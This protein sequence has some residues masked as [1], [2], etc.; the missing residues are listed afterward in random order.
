MN[1]N[2]RPTVG[3]LFD[4]LTEPYINQLICNI[5]NTAKEYDINIIGYCSGSY[6][7]PNYYHIQRTILYDFINVDILDGII[8]L[9]G[10]IGNYVNKS[11]LLNL[12]SRYSKIP[13]V[14]IG[15]YLDGVPSIIIDNKRGMSDLIKHLIEEHNCKKIAYI[16]G[17]ETAHDAIE[18][19]EAYKESLKKHN[20]D[21]DEKLI[22]HGNFERLY[23]YK[24]VQI[25]KERK[26]TFDA[27]IGANDNMAIYAMKELM[28]NGFKIP[29]DIA[30]AGFDNINECMS[31]SPALTSVAQPFYEIAK[32]SIDCILSLINKKQIPEKIVIPATLVVRESCGC[33]TYKKIKN[34]NKSFIKKTIDIKDLNEI[35]YQ[36]NKNFNMMM[37]KISVKEWA[38]K[39][40]EELIKYA[41]N[42][43]NNYLIF[44][45]DIIENLLIN[46]ETINEIYKYIEY[47]F[48]IIQ[49]Y[50]KQNNEIFKIK[51][52]AVA[53]FCFKID[54][55]LTKKR[56][57]IEDDINIVN[58]ITE[59]LINAYE[60]KQ[61][62]KVIINEFSLLHLKSCYLC[63]YK[64]KTY[65]NSIVFAFFDKLN[66]HDKIQE[67]KL[68]PTIN[69][70][71]NKM[72]F[73]YKYQYIVFDLFVK[74]EQIGYVLFEAINY[75]GK[76]YESLA[77]QLSYAIKGSLLTSELKKYTQKLERKVKER[78][79][80]LED[81][82]KKLKELDSLKND[83]I[84]NITHEFRSPL[85]VILGISELNMLKTEE[86]ENYEIIHEASIKL[87]K[88]IDRLLHL[89][90][91]DAGIIKLNIS[92]INPSVFLDKII[93]YYSLALKITN[94][95]IIK[96]L[97]STKIDDFYSDREKLE[98]IINNI[99]S[100]S[101][102]FVD[103]DNGI[104]N[105]ELYDNKDFIL[106]IISDNGIGI[107]KNQ[108]NNIFNRFDQANTK[109]T[110]KY[111]GTGIGLAYAKQLINFMKG[112]IWAESEGEGKGAK[113]L[114][115][116]KKG[117][118]HFNIK[119]I[120]IKKDDFTNTNENIEILKAK[121]NEDYNNDHLQILFN[122]LN[123]ENEYEHHKGKI[124]IIDD[125][126]NIRKIIM[127]YLI[128][129]NFQNFILASNGYT[130]INAIYKYH[131][132][133]II[134]DYNLNDI[135]GDV[136]HNE[137]LTNP[138]YKNIPFVFLSA[139][140]DQNIINER[141]E[142]G[143][144][145]YIKK[146]I[147][148]KEFI[149]TINN[150]LVKYFE[151]KK[152]IKLASIDELTGLHNRR[153]I[154][155]N[156]KHEVSLRYYRNISI[157]FFDIDDFKEINDKFG[158][159]IGDIVIKEV[160]KIIKDTI[161]SYD[162]A[163]RYGGDEFVI[164]LPDTNLENAII[165]AEKL[166]NNIENNR[167]N[168]ENN[169][170]KITSSFGVSS[171]LENEEYICNSLNIK[172]L[173]YIYEI[174]NPKNENWDLIE[175]YKEYIA[176]ILIKMADISLYKAKQNICRK[177]GFI[178]QN[179]KFTDNK[180]PEC[181]S[182]DIIKGKNKVVYFDIT[183]QR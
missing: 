91:I 176:N 175:K 157:I 155:N 46:D 160:G 124:L 18:R 67:N 85:T 106:I 93:N 137:I 3:I 42:Q 84:A 39:I 82:N 16:N 8:A 146:P 144:S 183:I 83:F 37:E 158:H 135:K 12:Y 153:S 94:I 123:N 100:N 154:L 142:R 54:E 63:L 51:N 80:E 52:E 40:I 127:N 149:I 177:C 9:S 103:K 13:I 172:S 122:N 49:Q 19:F 31:N 121:F 90:Q 1:T 25:F 113:F 44:L 38:D 109:I 166:K 125:D 68:F 76:F 35:K 89:A 152:I 118:A 174:N 97:P 156:L 159:P 4:T 139:I 56:I 143:A 30:V 29:E 136:I 15:S 168:Y 36:I 88:S 147:V 65:K 60:R 72:D 74:N 34:I 120:V 179:N 79:L 128:K 129:N 77:S 24:A 75:N 14:S 27:L 150:L 7:C 10:A 59:D 6:K 41:M 99:V 5:Y 47:Q 61:L 151:L 104:I 50:K 148:E 138:E 58:K 26:A 32:K 98:E 133:I 165:V 92:K 64:D 62:K 81:A 101:I 78:T 20:I 131:P 33:K 169:I 164:V 95:K 45:E 55:I 117:K 48:T 22:A 132:D 105:I 23:G 180:C 171:L 163:G 115:Q 73:D 134:C 21:Y 2:H 111:K 87:K 71:P 167:M 114:I 69:L 11:D 86:K 96:N 107:D 170:I 173:K 130:G 110:N 108:L 43:E 141:R 178:S 17:P 126:R 66:K 102:K 140:A 28:N 162:I 182:L 53:L 112:E 70:L 57:K 119:D 161:R 145:A 116:L 181:G